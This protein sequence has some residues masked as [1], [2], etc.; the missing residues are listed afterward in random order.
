MT[1]ATQEHITF[2]SD[3]FQLSG[4][5]HLPDIPSPPVVIGSHGLL[6]NGDSPKQIRL[7]R[8][9]N[10]R[11]M[12]Y[13]RFDH[14]GCG[15]SEGDFVNVTTLDARHNDLVSALKWCHKRFGQD[16]A[17]GLFGSSLGGA[18][19]LSVA[20]EHPVGALVTLAA[21]V[22]G[23]SIVESADASSPDL[24]GLPLSFYRKCLNFDVSKAL[25]SVSRILI[26]HGSADTVVPVS[27]SRRIYEEA[28]EP[29][30]LVIQTKGD[31]RMSRTDHQEV[32]YSTA[33]EWFEHHLQT[34]KKRLR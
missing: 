6:S 14:R 34:A 31:H 8:E 15:R 30:E 28:K 12:A 29:K 1:R 23:A 18:A 27:N 9:C 2:L 11:G 7:A 4:M 33:A 24:K 17:T 32:F 5:L 22:T 21:P 26:F 25:A 3:G 10:R 20:G 16:R 19:A 13:L